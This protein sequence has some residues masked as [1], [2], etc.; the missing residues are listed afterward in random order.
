MSTRDL[1]VGVG[2]GRD[3]PADR[4][5]L[6]HLADDEAVRNVLVEAVAQKASL[7]VMIARMPM[8]YPA[9]FSTI[10]TNRF[11]VRP[12]AKK[13]RRPLH[14]FDAT[15]GGTVSGLEQCVSTLQRG[16][17]LV[18]D[19]VRVVAGL[20]H[21]LPSRTRRPARPPCATARLRQDRSSSAC[22]RTCGSPPCD[23]TGPC[24]SAGRPSPTIPA[25][26]PAR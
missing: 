16:L 11:T 26:R 1:P 7:T 14:R 20:G 4:N 19:L 23:H 24:T 25:C 2:G 9:V 10:V 8:K 13:M 22:G 12:P 15:G 18:Q 21:R 17:E 6:H 3:A 5:A